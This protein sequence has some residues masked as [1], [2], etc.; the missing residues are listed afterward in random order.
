MDV[1]ESSRASHPLGIFLC[2]SVDDKSAVR[3]LYRRL[4]RDGFSPWLD[5]K[6][7]LAGQDWGLE[8]SKAVRASD[9]III[10]LSRTSVTKRGYVQKEI[11][12]ALDVADEHPEG[13]IFIV[14]LKLEDCDVPVRLSRWHWVNLFEKNG[15]KQL[16]HMLTRL[17]A[18]T[19]EQ[20]TTKPADDPSSLVISPV[21]N[22]KNQVADSLG[23]SHMTFHGEQILDASDGIASSIK[24]RWDSE[25]TD[26]LDAYAISEPYGS[27]LGGDF[28]ARKKIDNQTVG[29][30]LVDAQGRG[31]EGSMNM[32]PLM[33][34]FEGSWNSYSA[35]H[36]MSQLM[37]ASIAVGVH[38]TAIYCIISVIDKKRW[39]SVT[40]AAHEKLI[41]F[42]QS[43]DGVWRY[44]RYP[45]QGV[46]LGLPFLLE[47]VMEHRV[48][49][50]VGTIIIGYTDGIVFERSGV[51]E[52]V[53]FALSFINAHEGNVSE[54]AEAIMKWARNRDSKGFQDDA[55]VFV[56]QVK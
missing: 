29:I 44:D 15:Y 38:G 31:V 35:A 51:T 42:S 16:L 1:S 22:S 52:L 7:L 8:I 46:M 26:I 4:R 54:L 48:E 11:K 34:A 12:F 49:I 5:E 39:L 25:K 36:V 13:A 40:S 3:K 30:L 23:I 6:N 50:P 2:Y 56:A 24:E 9:V 41:V 28:F 33:T 37:K 20:E 18:K 10:C 45:E 14:P 21:S 19:A 43:A 17:L 27:K 53:T 55:T 32:L 47:P